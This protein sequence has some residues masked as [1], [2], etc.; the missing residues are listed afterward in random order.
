MP[1]QTPPPEKT[2]SFVKDNTVLQS[3]WKYISGI[4]LLYN[5]FWTGSCIIKLL[6]P[7]IR[8]ASTYSLGEPWKRAPNPCTCA[9][10]HPMHDM[11]LHWKTRHGHH[12]CQ[13]HIQIFC[14]SPKSKK[15]FE[16]Q[17]MPFA[18]LNSIKVQHVI[19]IEKY[20]K[21]YKDLQL[22]ITIIINELSRVPA[23]A[24]YAAIFAVMA[25]K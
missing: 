11:D 20:L 12:Q 18:P 17:A 13:C 1:K 6:I 4:T 23:H 19:C 25:T 16:T 7:P 24:Q 14:K 5:I 21:L 10:T 3:R 15:G 2:L 9:P 8:Y 22:L